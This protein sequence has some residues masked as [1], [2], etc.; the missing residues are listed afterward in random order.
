M[1][2]EIFFGVIISVVVKT[3]VGYRALECTQKVP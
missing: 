2:L 3:T 1:Q